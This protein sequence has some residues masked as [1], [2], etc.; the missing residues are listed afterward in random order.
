MIVYWSGFSDI[1]RA[2]SNNRTLIPCLLHPWS[3]N[4]S[5]DEE[6]CETEHVYDDYAC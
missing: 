3:I 6:E 5:L 2:K 1:K 4:L